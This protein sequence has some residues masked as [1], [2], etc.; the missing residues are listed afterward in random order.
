MLAVAVVSRVVTAAP[1][2]EA[3]LFRRL[4]H[5]QI[6]P[7]ARSGRVPVAE[8]R[9]ESSFRCL[10]SYRRDLV[11]QSAFESGVMHTFDDE[12]ADVAQGCC[13]WRDNRLVGRTKVGLKGLLDIVPSSG[14]LSEGID[15]TTARRVEDL[16]EAI[17]TAC[18]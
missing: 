11:S 16:G 14:G 8:H 5:R 10:N 12:G 9:V 4:S 18:G 6:T 7:T 17:I 13:E 1:Q 2:G 3:T 15:G